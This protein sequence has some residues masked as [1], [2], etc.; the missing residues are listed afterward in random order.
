[1]TEDLRPTDELRR[2]AKAS[3]GVLVA[4][5]LA[6]FVYVID[7]TIMSVSISDLVVDLD[8]ELGNIQMAITVYTLT[9][10]AFMITGGKLGDIWGARK[11][12]RIGLVVYGIG[13][14]TTALSP[15]I[16]TLLIGWSILEGLGSA[17]IV[18]AT[19]TL[20]RANFEGDKRAA[21]YGTLGGVAAAG[22]AFGP[23]IGGWITTTYTW[24]LA[25]WIEAVIVVGVLLASG[26]IKEAPQEGPVLKLDIK[27]ATFWEALD[28]V[29]D[30][31]KLVTYAFGGQENALT[32]VNRDRTTHRVDHFS[33]NQD[34][35][36]WQH[37]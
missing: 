10:A 35:T 26:R 23:I 5:A 20:V 30:Q 6:M 22:A 16:V 27:D 7:T 18:P 31:A 12:F 25:F 4:L 33:V 8:T 14:V 1:M 34:S 29:L 37:L 24:R 28:Q 11:A 9:M 21:A 3:S 17:L 15:N 19:N 32:G 36:T 2:A 13:T